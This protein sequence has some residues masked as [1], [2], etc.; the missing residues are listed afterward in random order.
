[1]KKILT[2]AYYY[3]PCNQVFSD[4][5]ESFSNALSEEYDVKVLLHNEQSAAGLLQLER[6]NVKWFLSINAND[7]PREAVEAGKTTF[8][9]LSID[10]EEFEFSEGFT[11]LHT[12]SYK[13]ILAGNGFPLIETRRSIGL[14]SR[15]RTK[16]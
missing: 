16:I 7:L 3:P 11:D 12:D 2:I 14:V 10:G 9:S 1:M 15:M 13:E 5:V 8:R 6:A 4:R